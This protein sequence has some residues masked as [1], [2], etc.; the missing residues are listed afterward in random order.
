M[1]I[2][3][4]KENQKIRIGN[5]IILNIVSISDNH[6]KIGI[7]AD[8]EV[9]IFR[10]EVYQQIIENNKNSTAKLNKELPE[11]LKSLKINKI[12]KDDKK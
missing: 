4:R 11:N 7:E 3:T 9:A 12:K 6:V 8:K 1:L 2:L 5:N 10:E